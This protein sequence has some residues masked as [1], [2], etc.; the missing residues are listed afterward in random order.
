MAFVP[1]PATIKVAL[2]YR[3]AGNQEIVNTL[4]FKKDTGSIAFADLGVVEAAVQV[5]WNTNLKPLIPTSVTLDRI[6][7]RDVSA[8]NSFE[9][10]LSS[11]TD[12]LNPGSIAPLS[13]TKRINFGT[14]IAGRSFKGANYW[15][16]FLDSDVGGNVLTGTILRKQASN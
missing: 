16:A 11:N 14:G 5:W 10:T 15:P 13:V 6:E 12:G 3:A 1:I 7:T 4:Y 2:V 8:Q 9:R